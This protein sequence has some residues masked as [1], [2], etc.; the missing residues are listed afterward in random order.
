[1]RGR[2]NKMGKRKQENEVVEGEVL[3][4]NSKDTKG[5]SKLWS[6]CMDTGG[7]DDEWFGF[8]FD[9]PEFEEGAVVEF[10]IEEN[11]AGY[12]NCV[13]GTVEV[14]EDAPK[15]RKSSKRGKSSSKPKRGS[16]RSRDDD[17]DDD[18]TP[19]KRGGGSKSKSSSRGGGKSTAKS[20]TK[21]ADV[22][23]DRKDNLIRLQSCQNTAI[24]FTNML[25]QNDCIALKD[26]KGKAVKKDTKMDAVAAFVEEEAERLFE[27]YTDIVDGNYDGGSD[28]DD[29]D[30]DDD[31]IPD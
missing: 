27:K 22:D 16:S 8:G 13:E 25:L 19:R 24:A 29:D 30:E 15:K 6:V 2:K 26:A 1:M 4:I 14:I 3:K 17:D 5:K 10:E 18:D 21:K 31:D 7:D 9:E 12:L 20:G 11:A 28:R 23:W